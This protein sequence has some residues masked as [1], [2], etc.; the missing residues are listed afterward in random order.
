LERGLALGCKYG[1]SSEYM[2]T[3]LAGVTF[4][5]VHL[6]PGSMEL[7][8][9]GEKR[10][11]LERVPEWLERESS[12]ILEAFLV[13]IFFAS[14]GFFVQVEV[15]L[16]AS[17]L[18][19]GLVCALVAMIGKLIAGAWCPGYRLCVGMAM[20]SRG[21][22]GLVM[23]AE[24]LHLGL[25]NEKAF[26]VTVWGV[27]LNTLLAPPIFQMLLKRV[28]LKVVDQ[29]AQEVTDQGVEEGK[30]NPQMDSVALDSKPDV[31]V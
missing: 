19:M 29:E 3:F 4:A 8:D 21:E 6:D 23:A 16:D 27:L 14:A 15:L 24:S 30:G 31:A 28:N 10:G 26:S 20:A 7:T 1:K 11:K 9:E 2:G 17:T 12:M 18:W 5:N 25:T 13:S 22:L